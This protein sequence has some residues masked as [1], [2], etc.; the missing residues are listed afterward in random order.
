PPRRSASGGL[1]PRRCA[2]KENADRAA[3]LIQGRL[4]LAY[5]VGIVL[6]SGLGGL[7]SSVTDAV[8]IPYAEIPGFPVSTVSSHTSEIVAGYIEGIPVIV[9]SGR[10]HYF[11]NGDAGVMRTPIETLKAIGC[12]TLILTNSDGSKRT[13][14]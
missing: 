8:R 12:D 4:G 13:E 14:D 5:E 7:A 3:R 11:E 2:M 9:L 1:C 6:G 10:G